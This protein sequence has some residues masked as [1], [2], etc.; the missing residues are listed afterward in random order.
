MTFLYMYMLKLWTHQLQN[1]DK[2]D[3]YIEI[4]ILSPVIYTCTHNCVIKH[5][6]VL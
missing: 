2:E 1:T 5:Y 3:V 4:L 6:M